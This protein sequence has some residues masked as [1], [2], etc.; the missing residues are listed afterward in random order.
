MPRFGGK[1]AVITG[2]GPGIGGAAS[3]AFA[4]EG[5]QVAAIDIDEAS[6]ERTAQE[7]RDKGGDAMG[8]HCDVTS[9]SD[10]QAMVQQ[11]VERF[12]R[13][14][15]LFN[16]AGIAPRGSVVD[17]P[18]EEWDRVLA[19][20]LTSV[21]L[22]T[23]YVA[24][25]M[26]EHGGGPLVNTGSMCSLHG[27]KDLAAYTAAKGGV[28]VLTKQMAVDLKPHGIR[29]NC[30]CPGVIDTPLVT[31]WLATPG[32]REGVVARHPLG[33]IG[34]PEEVAAAVA[35]LLSDD[36]SFITGAILAVDGGSLAQGR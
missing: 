17:T 4:A 13:V 5:A 15:I 34:R 3:L 32:T 36:A 11:V 23:K 35:F 29:V 16:N 10:V 14:D 24:P 8:V 9:S 12:G 19:V 21:F 18:E 6:A 30:V 27:Y 26:Q 28:L 7:I 2:G 33:R 25:V 1:V 22:C 20:D 31:K